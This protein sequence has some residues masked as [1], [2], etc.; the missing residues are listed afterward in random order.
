MHD[1]NDASDEWADVG[2]CRGQIERLIGLGLMPV[3]AEIDGQI[4]GEI[5]MWWG[6]DVSELG[7][8]LDIA[9]L[10]VHRDMH[11]QGIGALLVECVVGIS[12][13]HTCDGVGIR[14]HADDIACMFSGNSHDAL[15]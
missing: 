2:E 12:R 13:E 5:K 3:V 1:S 9:T 6:E 15:D 8:S 11:H 10:F 7:R 4:V 14:P